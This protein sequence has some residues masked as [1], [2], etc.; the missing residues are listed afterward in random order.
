MDVLL[1]IISDVHGNVP[2]LDEV[3]ADSYGRQADQ[4]LCLGDVVGYGADPEYCIDSVSR[5]CEIVVKGNHDAGVADQLGLEYFNDPGARAADW[6]RNLLDGR[7]IKWLAE[8][9]ML[10]EHEDGLVLCHSYPPKPESWSYVLHS[11]LAKSSCQSFPGKVCLVGHTH[12]AI[13][14]NE[15]GT[16]VRLDSG[17]LDDVC[18]INV[19]SV[20][21]PRDGDPRAAYLTI[22]TDRRTWA[23]HRV[24][25]DI[26]AAA[27]RIREEGL[28]EVLWKRLYVGR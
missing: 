2:A 11:H 18:L 13:A 20:G 7:R 5:D 6:S 28:P 23:H 4:T 27:E 16:P 12:V 19:G 22:D 25:Y 9:P 21:Q 3:M 15:S 1:R 10:R 24:E 14:W 8:L 26:D 17:G